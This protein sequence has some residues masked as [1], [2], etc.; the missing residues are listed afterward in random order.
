[1]LLS[2]SV[3]LIGVASRSRDRAESFRAAFRLAKAWGSYEEMLA[4]SQIQAVYIPLPNGLHAEWIIKAAESGKHV[5]CEKPLATCAAEAARVVEVARRTGAR[6]MEAFMWR[7]H[8]QHLKAKA[9]V[10]NGTIG[11][12]GL[13]RSAFTFMLD[14]G[15]DVRF[16][17][18]LGGGCILDVG[19]YPISASRFYFASEPTTV[20]ARADIDP[21]CKVD[22]R[23][24]AI[25]DFPGGRASID[26]AFDLPYRTEVELV[27]DK[28]TLL[29]T[30]PWRPDPEA[31]LIL[32]GQ[33]ETF[34]SENQYVTQFEHFSQCLLRGTLPGYGPEDA[35]KQVQVIDALRRSVDS[36]LPEPVA[37]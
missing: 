3:S 29:L 30:R 27:G 26:A 1:M 9:A 15:A 12:L 21:S 32:N 34:A 2:P 36:G 8:L 18:D 13:V 37:P 31:V 33:V 7:F 5:L 11:R 24:C 28:G 23:M 25:V 35:L 16:D 22:M 17:P 6:V 19:C 10:E 20:W 14:R 4:D